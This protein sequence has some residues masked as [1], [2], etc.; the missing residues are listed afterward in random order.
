[1]PNVEFVQINAMQVIM[2]GSPTSS[3][4]VDMQN[5]GDPFSQKAPRAL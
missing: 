1:M 4:D 2:G 3:Q 5:P